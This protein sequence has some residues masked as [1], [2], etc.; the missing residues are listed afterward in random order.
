M[1]PLLLI[2]L[3][4]SASCRCLSTI[5]PLVVYCLSPFGDLIVFNTPFALRPCLVFQFCCQEEHCADPGR[6]P[7]E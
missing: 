4:P 1:L 7:A 2:M 6:L 5:C 3:N